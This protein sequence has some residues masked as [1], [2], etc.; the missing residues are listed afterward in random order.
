M[1]SA[2]A[3]QFKLNDDGQ[4][5]FQVSAS[6]PLPGKA[7]AKI[8]KGSAILRPELVLLDGAV[9]E[10]QDKAA[11]T[12]KLV[13]WLNAHIDDVLMPLVK[14]TDEA[15]I[16]ETARSITTKLYDGLGI[17][18]R[19]ELEQLI[20]K[21]D[22]DGRRAMRN[23]KVRLG[24]VL[25]FL[26]ALNK[27]A[28]VHLRA[29]LWSLWNDNALPPNVPADGMVSFSVAGKDDCKG[30]HKEL[31]KNYM[32]SIGYPVYGPRAIRVDMLDRLIVAVYDGSADGK[33][34]AKHEMAEWLGCSI[35][36]LYAVLEAMGHG[37]IYDPADEAEKTE[38]LEKLGKPA[39][40]K[41]VKE[42]SETAVDTKAEAEI[43]T[44][45]G[46]IE[47][48]VKD[49][50]SESEK[51]EKPQIKPELA[52]FKLRKGR[53]YGDANAKPKTSASFKAMP[54]KKQG[55]KPKRP[56]KSKKGNSDKK[57]DNSPRVISSRPEKKPGIE[58]S[59]FAML[60]DLKVKSGDE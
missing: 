32:R 14:L 45:I 46:K 1:L 20:G 24:P 9:I 52:T 56:F 29:V 48:G 8:S 4:V 13:Q 43:E 11:V 34:K 26:P 2:E 21:L 22:D 35:P 51:E 60:K 53:A 40:N 50:K 49:A 18:P 55:D 28:A 42:D 10:G 36:D 59:P 57:R 7:V 27:P 30:D 3:K 39:E 44:E 25:V 15:E 33:F 37:K 17:L 5:L 41:V 19:S 54:A 47:S 12:E 31:D 23:R 38:K 6:N 58:N 16:T